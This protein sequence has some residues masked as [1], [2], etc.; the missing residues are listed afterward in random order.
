MDSSQQNLNFNRYP[1]EVGSELTSDLFYMYIF[2][3]SCIFVLFLFVL[4]CFKRQIRF[5]GLFVYN[6]VILYIFE[7]RTM[8]PTFW[9]EAFSR[10]K[11]RYD[12]FLKPYVFVTGTEMPWSHYDVPLAA[13]NALNNSY[14]GFMKYCAEQG[15]DHTRWRYNGDYIMSGP[16]YLVFPKLFSFNW[17][18]YSVRFDSERITFTGIDTF[19]LPNVFSYC[20]LECFYSDDLFCYYECVST[21]S[22]RLFSVL[23]SL[24]GNSHMLVHDDYT[25]SLYNFSW[26]WKLFYSFWGFYLPKH[27]IRI[28]VVG[29]N[30]FVYRFVD[31]LCVGF[32]VA[33]TQALSLMLADCSAQRFSG[34]DFGKIGTLCKRHLAN[35]FPTSSSASISYFYGTLY[36]SFVLALQLNV[37]MFG[38]LADLKNLSIT[39]NVLFQDW[40]DATYHQY[41]WYGPRFVLWLAFVFYIFLFLF[42]FI[43]VYFWDITFICFL[44][45]FCLV[46]FSYFCFYT[47]YY[48][49][50]RTQSF[51]AG[52][53]IGTVQET[54]N[55]SPLLPI[56]DTCHVDYVAGS[57]SECKD[58]AYVFAPCASEHCSIASSCVHNGY[59]ACA[60]RNVAEFKVD[61]CPDQFCEWVDHVIQETIKMDHS[62]VSFIDEKTWASRF[63]GTKRELYEEA[64]ECEENEGAPL[65]STSM[66]AFIKREIVLGKRDLFGDTCKFTPRL[67]VASKPSFSAKI[68]AKIYTASK[69]LKRAWGG[70]SCPYGNVDV[71][72][73]IHYTA[74]MNKND[75]GALFDFYVDLLGEDAIVGNFD[76]E[77]YDAH[78]QVLH[79]FQEQKLYKH[80][81]K[82][83]QQSHR[84]NG[85]EMKEFYAALDAQIQRKGIIKCRDGLL[86]AIIDAAR[87]SG[88]Q[89]TSV[90]NSFL[91][92][93][94]HSYVLNKFGINLFQLCKDNKAAI[95]VM[96]D[97]CLLWFHSSLKQHLPSVNQYRQAMTEIGME[98]KG[99]FVKPRDVDYCS[100]LF[101]PAAEGTVATQFPGRNLCKAYVCLRKYSTAKGAYWCRQTAM[102]YKMDFSH[103]PFMY[104]YHRSIYDSVR[105]AR[106]QRVCLDEYDGKHVAH[107][108]TVAQQKYYIFM[109][110]RYGLSTQDCQ[111]LAVLQPHLLLAHPNAKRIID[112]DVYGKELGNKKPYNFIDM[113]NY[114]DAIPRD[115]YLKP[116]PVV[117]VEKKVKKTKKFSDSE[118]QDCPSDSDFDNKLGRNFNHDIRDGMGMQRP[119]H[120]KVE[121]GKKANRKEFSV[122]FPKNK[123]PISSNVGTKSWKKIVK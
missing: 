71:Y 46:L 97:D 118:P 116:P 56:R 107:G 54:C 29:K 11:Q 66:E 81:Y 105:D 2:F 67:I 22:T 37:N 111:D 117:D 84:F 93:C 28:F 77:K 19:V 24:D 109:Y 102:A 15:V 50:R 79:L 95:W 38:W 18:G 35:V 82:H 101:F 83:F 30:V 20:N 47:L 59:T 61:Q 100:N 12:A 9:F 48:Y 57:C 110:D 1:S 42:Y 72:P 78:L 4:Y 114:K 112:V 58:G 85:M 21:V 75:L 32:M 41:F 49:K 45:F 122:L 14:I 88:D 73:N 119:N 31:N 55:P 34:P 121:K 89:N 70:G 33:H 3:L 26:F 51:S 74:G 60:M 108:S 120:A 53:L 91:N 94:F 68:G 27:F 80:L 39:N 13:V 63:S 99:E 96:G 69:L 98:I 104:N 106:A 115:Q 92:V 6:N 7:H 86:R 113:P 103:V 25:F 87:K 43:Y 123:G 76:F 64:I 40:I 17:M 44:Y 23:D 36:L 52:V 10:W 8:R 5:A 90:G 62:S 65:W 16:K